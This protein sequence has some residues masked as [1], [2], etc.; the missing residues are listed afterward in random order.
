VAKQLRLSGIPP[1]PA[2]TEKPALPRIP[3]R[4]RRSQLWLAVHL[5]ELPLEVFGPAGREEAAVVVEERRGKMVVMTASAPARAQGVEA[6]M[7]L[8]AACAL[9]GE[10]AIHPRDSRAERRRLERL[11]GVAGRFTPRVVVEPPRDLLL[12]IGASLRL[13]GG[14]NALWRQLSGSLTGL[15]GCCRHAITPTPLASLWLARC[16][17]PLVLTS[18]EELRSA[19]GDLPLGVLELEPA[20]ER[21]LRNTGVKR[22]RDLWRL[23]RKG[24]ARRFGTGLLDT[25]DRALGRESDLRRDHTTPP[26]FEAAL[27]FAAETRDSR[28]ILQGAERLLARLVTFLQRRDAAVERVRFTLLRNGRPLHEIP[29]GLRQGSRDAGR[30]LDLL[31][32]RL[33]PLRL[34]AP[35]DGLALESRAIRPFR[36]HAQPLFRGHDTPRHEEDSWHELLELLQNR[37]GADAVFMLQGH[38]DHRP[39]R[40]WRHIRPTRAP[41]ASGF[42][43]PRRPL[44]LLPEPRPLPAPREL[45]L[46]SGPERIEGGWWDGAA[47]R[48]DYYVARDGDGRRLWIFRDPARPQ[49]WYLHGLFG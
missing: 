23:P 36:P 32:Q 39:E 29:I 21:R 24:L 34:A 19:L 25:L 12:E 48:R 43:L 40:A 44:W 31:E 47:I 33:N 13:F 42:A 8:A 10:L 17:R 15:T 18:L 27:E 26:R 41:D 16:N 45:R 3:Q 14:I 46:L 4:E 7:E 22:L 30:L 20:L 11:A 35:I 5:P 37:L 38:A 49:L 2:E 28:Q 9:C 1:S 6:G